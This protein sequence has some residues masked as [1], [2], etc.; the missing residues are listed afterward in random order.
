MGGPHVMEHGT[1]KRQVR[2]PL[3]APPSTKEGRYLSAPRCECVNV[4]PPAP[5]PSL[6]P[7]QRAPQGVAVNT[8]FVVVDL[9]ESC[10]LQKDNNG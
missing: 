9:L 1:G 8:I 3:Q 5:A 2:R 4:P 6:T 7:L 10:S